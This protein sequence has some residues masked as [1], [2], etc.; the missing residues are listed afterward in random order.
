MLTNPRGSSGDD[1]PPY[2]M[3]DIVV[4]QD[5]ITEDVRYRIVNRY[6]VDDQVAAIVR[7]DGDTDTDEKK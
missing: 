3:A 5:E 7:F 6:G 2:Y 1:N 4:E